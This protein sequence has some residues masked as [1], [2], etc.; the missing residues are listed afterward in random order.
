MFALIKSEFV[1]RKW[2]YLAY[3]LCGVIATAWMMYVSR[4]S[5]GPDEW[6]EAFFFSASI[7]VFISMFLGSIALPQTAYKTF[8]TENRLQQL[9]VMPVATWKIPLMLTLPYLIYITLLAGCGAFFLA[10]TQVASDAATWDVDDNGTKLWL[11]SINI[12]ALM[13]A[14]GMCSFFFN[15]LGNLLPKWAR[16]GG[17]FLAV[18]AAGTWQIVDHGLSKLAMQFFTET[19]LPSKGMVALGLGIAFYYLHQLLFTRVRRDLSRVS[20]SA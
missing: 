8:R 20:L 10:M 16:A 13:P 4:R 18:L 2:D 6:V 3:T 7:G 14:I 17:L 11:S 15:E 5:V 1:Y 12:G 19:Y 9:A